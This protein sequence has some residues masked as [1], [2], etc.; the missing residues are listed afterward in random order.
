MGA[1]LAGKDAGVLPT[2]DRF[3]SHSVHS[4]I[5]APMDMMLMFC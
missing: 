5:K 1:P 3:I 4:G 2:V